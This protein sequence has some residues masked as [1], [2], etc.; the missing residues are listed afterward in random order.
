LFDLSIGSSVQNRTAST[1]EDSDSE[2]G[3]ADLSKDICQTW[4]IVKVK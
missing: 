3:I 1:Q 4:S 2:E